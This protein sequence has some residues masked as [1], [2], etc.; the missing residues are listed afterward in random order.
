M[1]TAPPRQCDRCR[2]TFTGRR[3][4][5]RK[6]FEGSAWQGK[7]STRAWRRRRA[8]QLD[9]HP[10]CQWDGCRAVATE[11]DHVHGKAVDPFTVRSLCSAH[12]REA[13]QAQ[14]RVGRRRAR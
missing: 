7:G 9:E 5:C 13:T 12:H 1:P 14:A 11:V 6:P 10:L 2:R 3:C 8:Q 4:P